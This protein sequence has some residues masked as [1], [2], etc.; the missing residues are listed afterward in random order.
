VGLRPWPQRGLSWSSIEPR[1]IV[2][3]RYRELMGSLTGSRAV[4]RFTSGSRPGSRTIRS[5]SLVL[6]VSFRVPSPFLPPRLREHLRL[7]RSRF[8][9]SSRCHRASPLR[10]EGSVTSLRSVLSVSHALDGL[11]LARLHE[12]L[13][14]RNRVQDSPFQPRAVAPP[15]CPY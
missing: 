4:A 15:D 11:L 3:S 2:C 7:Y 12:L 6:F 8:S 10:C 13:S 1:S 5:F 14:S 9:S